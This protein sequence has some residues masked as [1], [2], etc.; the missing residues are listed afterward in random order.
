[1]S[2]SS[3]AG[4]SLTALAA[5]VGRDLERLDYFSPGWV[6]SRDGV[7]DVVIVGGG[8]SGLGAAFGLLRER[9]RNILVVDENPAGFE[10]PWDTYARMITLRTPK[11]LTG[12]DL[13]V[14]ALTCRAWWEAQYGSA[15]WGALDKIPRGAWM[16]YLRWFREVLGIP[17]RNDA[18]VRLIEPQEGAVHRLTLEG[19]ETLLARKV[20]LATGIQGGGEW[21]TPDF[22]RNNLPADRWAHTS[23]AIDFDALRGRRVGILGGGASAFDNAQHALNA[24]VAQVHVHIRRPALPTVTTPTWTTPPNTRSPTLS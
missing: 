14:G 11:H 15:A 17:V 10:G 1:M 5:E 16:A 9:V 2:G 3:V 12:I 23:Q 24:G 8:Q 13:G 19:G 21:H 7:F 20:V 4:G 6:R 22:I 18:M